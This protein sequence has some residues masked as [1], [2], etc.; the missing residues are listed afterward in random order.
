MYAKASELLH[1]SGL[2]FE[3]L[4]PLIDGDGQQGA[5][6]DTSRSTDRSYIRYDENIMAKHKAMLS[7]DDA[8]LY[9]TISLSIH[10]MMQRNNQ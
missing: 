1:D 8:A 9:Q 3:V 10:Q 4:L 5:P 6:A 7:P 2:P